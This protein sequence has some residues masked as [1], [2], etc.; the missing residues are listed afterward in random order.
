[1]NT[2]SWARLRHAEAL[3]YQVKEV[4]II[5]ESTIKNN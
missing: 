2:G 4:Y 1:M 3:S 5:T